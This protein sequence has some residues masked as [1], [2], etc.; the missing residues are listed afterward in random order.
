MDKIPPIVLLVAGV[1]LGL[2]TLISAHAA[3]LPEQ[4]A[5]KD[6]Y[7]QETRQ[8]G[9]TFSSFGTGFEMS[10]G[11]STGWISGQNGWSSFTNS[12]SQP[13]VAN[14]NPFSGAQHLRMTNDPANPPGTLIGAFSPNLGSLPKNL[15][16]RVS[17]QISL[18]ATGGASY[19]VVANAPSHGTGSWRVKFHESG[20][21]QVY[22]RVD[23]LNIYDDTGA[24]WPVGS[25]FNLTVE[26]NNSLNQ[27]DYFLNGDLIYVSPAD[28]LAGSPVCVEQVLLA[29]DNRQTGS[30]SADFDELQIENDLIFTNAFEQE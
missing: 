19:D 25:Y 29:N 9:Q 22:N 11:Y 8:A 12:S 4:G 13:Y 7:H 2:N 5:H 28:V 27:I 18:S 1:Q 14:N 24:F 6:F 17:L 23:G 15:F 10:Q 21:I 20:S 16:C 30:E 3:A 26:A